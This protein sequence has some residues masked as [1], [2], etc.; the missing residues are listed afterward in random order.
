MA[1]PVRAAKVPGLRAIGESQLQYHQEA[2][3]V[4][5][6]VERSAV[7]TMVINVRCQAVG[8][9]P[10]LLCDRQCIIR[11]RNWIA[12]L[13]SLYNEMSVNIE[14]E[15]VIAGNVEYC[16]Y[17]KL[18]KHHLLAKIGVDIVQPDQCLWQI[19]KFFDAISNLSILETRVH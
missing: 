18:V 8:T 13:G 16:P 9:K 1:F 5:A 10:Q 6:A 11:M 17:R 7:T 15:R 2:A 14:F 19:V 3:A 12:R 4:V